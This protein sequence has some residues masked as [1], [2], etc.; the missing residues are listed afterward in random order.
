MDRSAVITVCLV[1]LLML[2]LPAAAQYQFGDLDLTKFTGN[3]G[4][5]YSGAYGNVQSS[6]HQLNWNGS[7]ALNGYYYNPNFLS[8]NLTP[9]YDESRANSDYRSVGDSS[10]LAFSSAIFSGSHFPGAVS[11]TRDYNSS[12]NFAIPGVPDVT[13]HGNSDNLGVR[14]GVNLPDLPTF[15]A[16][17]NQSRGSA[18]LYGSNET[19]SASS[20]SFGVQS[21]YNLEGFHLNGNYNH[22]TTLSEVPAFLQS[23]GESSNSTSD[24]YSFGV[25]HKLPLSGTASAGFNHSDF[26]AEA[27]NYNLQGT[28]NNAFANVGLN[29]STKLSLTG[30]LNY[31][32]NLAAN[33]TQVLLTGSIP[34]QLFTSSGS[35]SLDI[36]WIA[37]YQLPFDI[38]ANGM[39]DRRDQ[40]FLGQTYT[41]WMFGGGLS[42]THSLW[43]GLITG[44]FRLA[45]FRTDGVAGNSGTNALS[46]ICNGNYSRDV[47][48]WR[49]TGNLSYSQ[50]QQTLLVSYLTSFYN[51]GA[52]VYHPIW[53]LRWSAAYA[54]SH[55]G[56]V[57]QAGTGNSSH[58]FSTNLGSRHVTAG[59]GFSTSN[60]IGVLT[61]VGVVP[62]PV[63]NLT[64]QILFGG[65]NYN[66]SLG[67]SP[68]RRLILSASYSFSHGNTSSPGLAS[69]YDTK[70]LNALVQYRFRQMG[71]TGGYS[72][73]QQGFSLS[74]G[75]PF[76][77]STFY[78]GINRWFDFF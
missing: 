42:T 31:V 46:V 33:L 2:A 57:Q 37:T 8:F 59:A 22:S 68:V 70:S 40:S 19:S 35:H 28:V 36:N 54:G 52:S 74:G 6:S 26:N 73:L 75:R 11:Y 4:A 53:R 20:R 72:R 67:S 1:G 23:L 29:P 5:G 7:A 27:G 58:S 14:W 47:G 12:G 49:F 69:S 65:K 63:P 78:V 38:A 13:T 61:P 76:D 21:Q 34:G 50:N 71:F 48:R 10:G 55:S 16:F 56:F 44:M 32:D 45:D 66:F 18:S 15:S 3:L 30:N 25:S 41:S 24:N 60:G 64:Q 17:Y 62:L 77:G 43:G 9:Y 51:Y 39:I